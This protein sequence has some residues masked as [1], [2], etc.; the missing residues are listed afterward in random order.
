MENSDLKYTKEH[1]WVR[2]E[3]DV[4]VVGITDHA[5]RSLGDITFVELPEVG[6]EVKK[7]Q[8]MAVV[9]SVKA[10][11]D[12]FAP[13]TG[14][15]KEVNHELEEH[16]ELLNRSP[17]RKGWLCKI[18]IMEEAQLDDLMDR[19]TYEKHLKDQVGL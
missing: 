1:E 4:A 3:D 14:M 18:I 5:Q 13:V 9:E 16:P 15:I 7:A 17:F 2:I 19:A 11:S 6:T 12:I 10:A 8:D